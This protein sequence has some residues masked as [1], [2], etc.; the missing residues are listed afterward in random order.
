[1][2]GGYGPYFPRAGLEGTVDKMV[3]IEKMGR[4]FG[5]DRRLQ[6]FILRKFKGVG[7]AAD[8]QVRALIEWLE[9]LP[10]RR[11]PGEI[12]RS[13]ISTGV[14]GL[15]GDCDDFAVLAI[16][17]ATSLGLPSKAQVV[18]DADG[19]G[20]HVRVLVGLPPLRPSFWVVVDPVYRSEPTW[21]MAK[22][23]MTSASAGFH[24]V[25]DPLLH[26]S[27]GTKKMTVPLW[28]FVGVLAIFLWMRPP[29][30]RPLLAT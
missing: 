9:S 26:G 4:K 19:N 25:Q 15:G 29:P 1:M 24:T 14:E 27:Q 16:A 18:A 20:F 6:E 13:P 30:S 7:S 3:L 21:A 10:Y 5:H 2:D 22:R 23:D 12:L 17:A 11:E 28:M 8:A